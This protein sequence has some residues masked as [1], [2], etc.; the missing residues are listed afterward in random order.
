MMSQID[1]QIILVEEKKNN[2]LGNSS[3]YRLNLAN[4]QRMIDLGD[5]EKILKFVKGSVLTQVK[6]TLSKGK[7]IEKAYSKK[8]KEKCEIIKELQ[9]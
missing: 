3:A 1:E 8:L 2:F 4:V 6:S 9:E 5:M 7:Y